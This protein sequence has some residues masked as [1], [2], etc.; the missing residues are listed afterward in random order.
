M[1]YYFNIDSE[2][3]IIAKGLRNEPLDKTELDAIPCTEV[4]YNNSD[5]YKV[6]VKNNFNIVKLDEKIILEKYKQQQKQ[7][8]KQSA[9]LYYNQPVT[10]NAGRVWNGGVESIKSLTM[11]LNNAEFMKSNNVVFYDFY[12]DDL[13]LSFDEAKKV[14]SDITNAYTNV[15][16]RKQLLYKTIDQVTDSSDVG[17]NTIK[18]YTW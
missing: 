15:L 3:L 7:V 8:I 13:T 4:Q 9:N 14:I 11:A 17:I 16:K 18:N 2:G 5:F 6:D 10:D 1:F 12:N